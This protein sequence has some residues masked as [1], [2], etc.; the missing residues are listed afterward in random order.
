MKKEINVK[1]IKKAKEEL[2]SNI[3][4]LLDKFKAEY[5]FDILDINYKL[6][7]KSKHYDYDAMYQN[8]NLPPLAMPD[9]S[10]GIYKLEIII[11]I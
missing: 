1:D 9:E 11:D 7:E 3:R 10:F 2:T 6:I 5:G 8:C 4:E